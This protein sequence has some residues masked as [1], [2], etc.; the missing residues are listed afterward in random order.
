MTGTIDPNLGTHSW[1]PFAVGQK[2]YG[3][4]LRTQATTGPVS[5]AGKLGYQQRDMQ[6]TQPRTKVVQKAYGLRMGQA[7]PRAN[8]NLQIAAAR[9]EVARR[10]G[11]PYP[12]TTPRTGA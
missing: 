9:A 8:N 6:R 5:A 10:Y 7:K 4:G 1:N 11:K 12:G 2:R 3:A